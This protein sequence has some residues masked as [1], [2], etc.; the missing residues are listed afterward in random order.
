[1]SLFH[2][3]TKCTMYTMCTPQIAERLNLSKN[4]FHY[5]T[6]RLDSG[7]VEQS[8]CIAL[9]PHFWSR[10]NMVFEKCSPL[11]FQELSGIILSDFSPFHAEKSQEQLR[12]SHLRDFA[13]RLFILGICM[14]AS[15]KTS[16]RP[17]AES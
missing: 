10:V 6:G 7:L 16:R 3:C 14:G 5:R 17:S 1:M 9:L 11:W 2:M 12:N 15:S 13:M 4:S 8:G